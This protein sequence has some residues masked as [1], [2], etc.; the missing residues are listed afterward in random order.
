MW[1]FD[2]QFAWDYIKHVC[3]IFA[4]A[5]VYYTELIAPQEIR[6]QRN[7]TANR[8]HHK[9]SKRNID[10]SNQ[11]LIDDDSYCRYVSNEG[12]IPFENYIRIDNSNIS[13]DVVAK[14]IKERFAL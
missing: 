10:I 3:E 8:L 1:P 2:Q 13:P 4:S 5:D 11:R 6:L 14:M 12:E 9:S 7:A